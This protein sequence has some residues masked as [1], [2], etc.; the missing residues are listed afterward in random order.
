MSKKCHSEPEGR[1]ISSAN[2]HKMRLFASLRVTKGDLLD[3]LRDMEVKEMTRRFSQKLSDLTYFFNLKNR[4]HMCPQH[5]TGFILI[6]L[7]VVA[8]IAIL[9]AMLLPALR[10][11]RK[12]SKTDS[13]YG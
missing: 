3:S 5:M 4:T 7:L 8:I 13:L 12:K 10:Q 2:P 11:A 6:E 1:R 9:A